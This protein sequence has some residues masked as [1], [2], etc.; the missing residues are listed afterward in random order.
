MYL[1]SLSKM[2]QLCVKSFID[3]NLEYHLYTYGEV[4]NIPEGVIVKDGNEILPASYQI[5]SSCYYCY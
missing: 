5:F 2:E 4:K 3:H 1:P